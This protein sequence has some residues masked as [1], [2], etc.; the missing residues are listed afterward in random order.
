MSTQ[1]PQQFPVYFTSAY[2]MYLD[3]LKQQD[4]IN[5]RLQTLPVDNF[6]DPMNANLNDDNQSTSE[7]SFNFSNDEINNMFPNDSFTQLN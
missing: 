1:G 3:Y 4:V 2:D 6:N 7:I 5:N